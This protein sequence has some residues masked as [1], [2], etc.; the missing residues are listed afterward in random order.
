MKA[1]VFLMLSA[2]AVESALC[3]SQVLVRRHP[4]DRLDVSLG[5][6]VTHAALT[7]QAWLVRQQNDDGSWGVDAATNQ[8]ETMTALFALKAFGQPESTNAIARG[9]AF[10]RTLK[11]DQGFP[12]FPFGA[13]ILQSRAEFEK[14]WPLAER[15]SMR[16]IWGLSCSINR[17][18]GVLCDSTGAM[19]AWRPE[20]ARRILSSQ[21]AGGVRGDAY[22]P[23]PKGVKW[24]DVSETAFALL[25]FFEL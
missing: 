21:R 4:G 7:A 2:L 20:I 9:E 22:W 14:K 5:N 18:G 23:A 13:S 11:L 6:E 10:L 17:A 12:A 3:D 25:A 8:F 19:Q 15:L 24:G 16:E 1:V